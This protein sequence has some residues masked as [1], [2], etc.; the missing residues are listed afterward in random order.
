MS[1]KT[2]RVKRE[3][4]APQ[5]LY[6]VNVCAP[7]A[8]EILGD[9]D[10]HMLIHD[11]WGRVKLYAEAMHALNRVVMLC[12]DSTEDKWYLASVEETP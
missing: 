11:W 2:K 8:L 3:P 6:E 7:G 12:H 10:N 1:R 9:V 4:K 5:T